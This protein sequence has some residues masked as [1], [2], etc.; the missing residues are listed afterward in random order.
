MKL[1]LTL[2]LFLLTLTNLNA[3]PIY[4]ISDLG[5][6]QPSQAF[7]INNKGE[8]AGT[9][10]IGFSYHV[11]KWCL[12]D[13]L[14]ILFQ[15]DGEAVQG[16]NDLG[17][18]VGNDGSNR[19]RLNSPGLQSPEGSY[20]WNPYGKIE[21]I[22]RLV[23]CRFH[24]CGINNFGDIYGFV[25]EYSD[26]KR[27][28]PAYYA[29]HTGLVA[30]DPTIEFGYKSGSF[31][32]KIAAINDQET[33]IGDGDVLYRPNKGATLRKDHHGF[34]K[35]K[36]GSFVDLGLH[37]PID[38]NENNQVL[39]GSFPHNWT[40]SVWD[41]GVFK[42]LWRGGFSTLATSI[43][44]N[45]DV[46]GQKDS[47]A[48]LWQNGELF[49]LDDL[50]EDNSEWSSLSEANDINDQGQIVGRGRHQGLYKAFLLTPIKAN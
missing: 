8:V 3:S 46:V 12:E 35:Y 14:A 24:V 43:N 20:L 49:F 45:G 28:K 25:M 7:C 17:Q 31:H 44:N 34:L 48:V 2:V 10:S 16:I 26:P 5:I 33:I 38:I 22:N 6:E 42:E 41:K 13:G 50:I 47:R 30:I 29:P 19:D 23:G 40:I 18:I 9:V 36:D 4:K 15:S 11:F 21:S 1:L 39:L 27:P 37:N 32:G